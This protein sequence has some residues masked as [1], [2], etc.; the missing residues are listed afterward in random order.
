MTLST[1]QGSGW[2]AGA[3][4]VAATAPVELNSI[5]PAINRPIAPRLRETAIWFLLALRGG[6]PAKRLNAYS[7][8]KFH[9]TNP[10]I[11]F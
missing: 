2:Y 3:E 7:K 4:A 5:D 9:S 8:V 6:T 10:N 1:A 11:N